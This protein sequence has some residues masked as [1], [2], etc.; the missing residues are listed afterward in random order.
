MTR[1]YDD[2][3]TLFDDFNSTFDG[4]N[5][6]VYRHA[7]I[8][9]NFFSIEKTD[10]LFTTVM[11]AYNASVAYSSSAVLYGG[12]SDRNDN[13]KPLFASITKPKNMAVITI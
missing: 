1:I 5:V 6:V 12:S 7:D 10:E 3:G 8:K 2:T 11:T 9:P 13:I 4:A